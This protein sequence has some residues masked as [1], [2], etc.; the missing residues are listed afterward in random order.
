M[1][2][3]IF[4]F[5]FAVLL[6]SFINKEHFTQYNKIWLLFARPCVVKTHAVMIAKGKLYKYFC[7][8]F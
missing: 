8:N 4:M 2:G 6:Y 3:C 5:G 7:S 1:Q